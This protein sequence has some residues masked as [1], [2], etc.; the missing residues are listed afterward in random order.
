MR[1][2]ALHPAHPARAL[3]PVAWRLPPPG[4][5]LATLWWLH[6]LVA[7]TAIALVYA[8][9]PLFDFSRIV[10][11]SWIPGPH[12]AWGGALLLAL[13]LG[14]A[15]MADR[16]VAAAPAGPPAPAA[17]DLPRGATGSLLACTLLAYAVWFQPLLLRP[18]L[19]LDVFAGRLFNLREIA[20]TTPGLTTMTQFGVAYAIA[21]A[22]LLASRVRPLAAW[23][24]LG[25]LAVVVLGTIRMVAWGERLALIELLVPWAVAWLAFAQAHR[26]SRWQLF[27][28]LPLAAPLLLYG[29]FTATEYFRSWTTYQR[30]Y[31][32]IWA[33]TLERLLAYYATASNNGIGLLAETDRWPQFSGR[34]VA[35]WLYLMPVV[36]DL[37]RD[38]VG[39]VRQQYF[40][41]LG[42]YARPE[43]NN[44]SGLFTI[45]F[46]I[47]YA[48]SMLYFLAVGMLIGRLWALWRLHSPAGVLFYPV[49]VLF[50]VELLR[51]NY[52]AATRF[53]PVALALLFLWSVARP[54]R[55]AGSPP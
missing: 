45:V 51:F 3:P 38:S 11:R 31:D 27:T 29:I 32:S 24:R 52:L 42:Q 20:P 26:P 7:V 2:P 50:L 6:P 12:Y 22:V 54:P 41:F 18:Q 21:H 47:G 13:A 28:L 36:G 44:P 53:F 16:R 1:L 46:D 8:S 25:M 4:R 14:I 15:A 49:M 55:P 30:E 34:F 23:E 33:F 9:F 43:F 10:P 40:A 35:E 5:A 17:F 19:L 37:L 48:G 39:D